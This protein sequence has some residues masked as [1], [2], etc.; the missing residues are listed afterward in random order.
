MKTKYDWDST[1]I[2][3]LSDKTSADILDYVMDNNESK[4]HVEILEMCEDLGSAIEQYNKNKGIVKKIYL[5]AEH[6][7]LFHVRAYN[8]GEAID[9]AKTWGAR[10]LGELREDGT[11][12]T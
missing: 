3:S 5:C 10:V 12:I 11:L 7:E 9:E 6:G 8:I 1:T 4:D 2:H